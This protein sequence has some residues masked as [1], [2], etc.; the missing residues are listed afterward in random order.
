MSELSLSEF[1]E[2]LNELIPDL[3]RGVLRRDTDE[4]TQGKITMPQ[5]LACQYL[6]REGLSNMTALANFMGVTT[7]A[8]TGVVD[9]LVRAGYVGRCFDPQD[10]R[11]VNIELS[12]KGKEMVK[13]FKEQKKRMA[14]EVFKNLTE[15]DRKNYLRIITQIK[16][17]L[18]REQPVH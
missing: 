5:L 3:L 11:V 2:R 15:A 6:C 1:A 9:R 13:K 7:A 16:D 8:V 18:S 14:I 12:A 10:R 17:V 4:L